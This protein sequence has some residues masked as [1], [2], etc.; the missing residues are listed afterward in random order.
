[1]LFHLLTFV[2]H[3]H[4]SAAFTW[5]TICRW[6][7]C[8]LVTVRF[9]FQL[10]QYLTML[11]NSILTHHGKS[12]AKIFWKI[13]ESSPLHLIFCK[14]TGLFCSLLFLIRKAQPDS[15]AVY[16][17]YCSLSSI[18]ND[19]SLQLKSHRCATHHLKKQ[20]VKQINTFYIAQF[21]GTV[22]INDF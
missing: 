13:S 5:N 17:A 10:E 18:D 15:T 9:L 14:V 2:N 21:C 1:M 19:V 22:A 11:C 8:C 7:V 20:L 12:N 4:D 16:V 3:I 6:L